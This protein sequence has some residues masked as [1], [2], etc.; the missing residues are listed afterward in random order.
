MTDHYYWCAD[1]M[2]WHDHPDAGGPEDDCWEYH[3]LQSDAADRAESYHE[4][5]SWR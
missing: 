1:C 5:R 3:L 2:D 4:E